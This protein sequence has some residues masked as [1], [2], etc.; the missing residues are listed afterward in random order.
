MFGDGNVIGNPGVQA[1]FAQMQIF[2][3]NCAVCAET[4]IINQFRSDDPLSQEDAAFV[5]AQN[6]WYVPGSG[7][8]PDVIGHLMDAY[9]IANHTVTKADI[10]DLAQ[11]LRLGHGVIVGVNSSELW[12][13][14]ALADLKHF[15]CK[16]FG[17]DNSIW[18][19]ADHAITVTGIDMS[20][21]D[22]PQVIINDSGAPN[23]NGAG[24]SYP[25]DK[26]LDAWE[27]SDFR[28]TATDV[29][30]PSLRDAGIDPAFWHNFSWADWISAGVG[31]GTAVAIGVN[32]GDVDFAFDGGLLAT[33]TTAELLGSEAFAR[34]I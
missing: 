19:P 5:S 1:D 34:M 25:L 18:Q 20:D 13:S 22:H 6:G 4:S 8:S 9:G 21:P 26:F 12:D 11:E 33:Q 17:L 16:S 28:Y 2:D 32:T 15:L 30:L 23:G 7:T 10:Q 24:V 14:G 31:I 29:P 3:D 27:N